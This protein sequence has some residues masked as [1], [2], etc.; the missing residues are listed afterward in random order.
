M[1]PVR[2]QSPVTTVAALAA[3]GQLASIKRMFVDPDVTADGKQRAPLQLNHPH[4]AKFCVLG[5]GKCSG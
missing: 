2:D 1:N 5:G 4:C 3:D